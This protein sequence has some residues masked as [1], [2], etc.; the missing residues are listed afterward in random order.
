[1]TKDKLKNI[2]AAGE[3]LT[4]EFKRCSDKLS[5]S[6]FETVAAFSNRYGGYLFL[7]IDDNAEI[8]GVKENAVTSIKKNF[9]NTLN[10]PERINPTLF[11]TLEEAILDEKTILWT[12]IPPSSQIVM[13]SGKIYDRN[14]D[15]DMDIS[16]NSELVAAI[17]SRKSHDYSERKIYPF[18][19]ESDLEI[20]RLMPKV[21]QLAQSHHPDHPWL[22]L[23]DMEVMQSAGLYAKDLETGKHG[24]NLAAILLFGKDEV[25]RNCTPNYLTDAILRRQDQDR[26]DDRLIV[27]T[28][29]IDAYESLIEFIAKHTL[30]RFFI[31]GTRSVSVRSIIAR[32]LVSNSLV[33]REYTS[34]YPAKIIIER[35]RIVTENWSIPKNPGRIDPMSFTPYPKNPLL[36]NFF[37]QIGRADTLGSGVRNLY[38]FTKIYSGGEPE[39]TDGD[40]FKTIVPLSEIQTFDTN[41]TNH[42]T[43]GTNHDTNGTNH[44]TNHESYNSVYADK[45]C[46]QLKVN[47]N[48]SYDEIAEK[49]SISRRTV[50]RDMKELQESGKIKRV[51]NNRNGY[52][53]VVE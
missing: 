26:Y 53:E 19:N 4:T 31:E 12:Y 38:K 10:N 41:G 30:D 23:S 47:P 14:E 52:W 35:D 13:F 45:I 46:A 25:I 36:A 22:A 20:K 28:N 49:L 51:G 34:A 18:A 42:D 9:V 50:S 48:L 7:G 29:L 39:L 8:S 40:V 21:R 17:H 27:T 33:H 15:G 44:G 5:N 3:G 37:V 1:M 11:L 43:N 2:I 32:E 6:V 24:F 16:R